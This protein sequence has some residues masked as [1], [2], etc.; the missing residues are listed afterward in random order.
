[1][2]SIR[3][4][5]DM[6]EP[7]L[8]EMGFALVRVR[9]SG[10]A[11]PVLQIMA[12][13]NDDVAMTV[14]DCAAI[15]HTVSAIL[16]VEDP[17]RGAYTLEVSSPGIDRPLIRP[18]DFQRYEGFEAKIEMRSAIGGRRRFRGRIAG[19]MGDAVRLETKEGD[20]TLPL[21]GIL[22]AKLVLTDELVAAVGGGGLKRE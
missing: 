9:L 5:E 17:I 15:S 8:S 21:D 11:R 1:M 19:M 3:R 4:I 14:D 7:A 16:D 18:R 20:V 12:E 13:H 22:Q 6:I 2:E 10:G